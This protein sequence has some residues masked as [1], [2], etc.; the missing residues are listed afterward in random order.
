MP[1]KGTMTKKEK[2]RAILDIR[3][4]GIEPQQV[5]LG[6]EATIIGRSKGD[7]AINDKEISSTHCQIQ[8]IKDVYHLFDMNST[9]GT[10]INNERIIKSRLDTNDV[11]TIVQTMLVFKLLPESAAKHI[12]TVFQSA[13]KN[14]DEFGRSS[15]V[16]TLIE[17]EVFAQQFPEIKIDVKYNDGSTD[18][19]LF[20]QEVVY[21][22]RA[23][24]F[25]KFDGDSEISRKHLAVKLNSNSEILIEDQGSTNGVFL[26]GT[27]IKGIHRVSKN[28]TIRIGDC[29]LKIGIV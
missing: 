5:K 13:P 17:S 1:I 15:V 16:D 14:Q 2:L 24:S 25:G 19:L 9:N 8:C 10:F 11:I 20:N 3:A 29:F 23:S 18:T 28:D 21:I 4:P 7:L 22:G 27:K 6:D 26:N 12:S